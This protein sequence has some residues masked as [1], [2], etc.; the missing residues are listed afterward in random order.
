MNVRREESMRLGRWEFR[1]TRCARPAAPESEGALCFVTQGSS[2]LATLGFETEP[3]RG[4]EDARIPVIR[5]NL[6][7]WVLA[8]P[9]IFAQCRFSS[10]G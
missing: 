10:D 9:V 4:S 5:L 2:F 1:Y 8:R 7:P 6:Q 3:R